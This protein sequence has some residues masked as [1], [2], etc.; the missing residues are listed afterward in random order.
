MLRDLQLNCS[1]L[2]RAE[3]QSPLSYHDY[4]TSGPTKIAPEEIRSTL[5][6]VRPSDLWK[7]CQ[8][9]FFQ[10]WQIEYQ[11]IEYLLDEGYDDDNGAGDRSETALMGCN[12]EY[13]LKIIL[14]TFLGVLKIVAENGLSSLHDF[15]SRELR[16]G[17]WN[18]KMSIEGKGLLL[19]CLETY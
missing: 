1:E 15:R 3:P 8:R 16:L 7:H 13:K 14:A 11:D 4:N 6:A 9:I 10:R 5:L 2:P 18:D 19:P 12:T 17:L